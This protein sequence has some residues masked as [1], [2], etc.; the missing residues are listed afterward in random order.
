GVQSGEPDAAGRVPTVAGGSDLSQ[1]SSGRDRQYTSC[2]ILHRQIVFS[3]Q[4]NRTTRPCRDACFRNAAAPENEPRATIARP[5]P[6]GL[7]LAGTLR[8][9]THPMG[10]PASRSVSIAVF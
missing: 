6:G 3:R 2:R 4:R 1:P 8:G 9:E 7:V 5:C 10:N